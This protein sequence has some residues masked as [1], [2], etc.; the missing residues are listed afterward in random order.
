M[1]PS[2]FKIKIPARHANNTPVC[3]KLKTQNLR[4]NNVA[5]CD[6]NICGPEKQQGSKF[7]FCKICDETS[8]LLE[9]ETFPSAN[10]W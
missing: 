5:I 2:D 8:G 9:L 10:G 6:G 1:D 3:S 4:L 7:R